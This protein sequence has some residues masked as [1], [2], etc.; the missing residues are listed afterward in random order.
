MNTLTIVLP[1]LLMLGLGKFLSVKQIVSAEAITGMKTLIS[2]VMLPAVIFNA[3]LTTDFDQNALMLCLIVYV[4]YTIILLL[5]CKLNHKDKYVMSSFLLA[6][7]EGGML[8]YPLFMSLYGTDSLSV[9]MPLDLGNILFA[10][11]FFIVLIQIANNPRTDKKEVIVHSLNSP[12]V[13][14]TAAAIILNI[15]GAGSCFLSTAI[16]DVY[17]SI[18]SMVSAPI[19][20]LVLISVGYDLNFVKELMPAVL[21]SCLK[22]MLIMAG[23]LTLMLT[24]FRGLIQTQQLLVA[25]V[26][27]FSLPPQFV[28]TVFVKDVNER[29]F[30][31]TTLSVY[32]LI[33]ITCFTLLTMFLPLY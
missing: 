28:T 12:L 19:T 4:L 33:T 29:R 7:T 11:T 1:I 13:I 6:G 9:L 17:R 23:C 30:V 25:C 14:C 26:L 8:G 31:A 10:F 22:R 21:K 24:V 16:G 3:I 32:A 5:S 18:I 20:A 15:T 27:Y 2:S